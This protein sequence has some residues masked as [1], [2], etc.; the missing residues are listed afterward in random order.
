MNALDP[1][2]EFPKNAHTGGDAA[3]LS[4]SGRYGSSRP[5]LSAA[6]ASSERY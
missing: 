3:G 4:N 2:N 5:G 6:S 1:T